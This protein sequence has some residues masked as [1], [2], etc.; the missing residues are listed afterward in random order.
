MVKLCFFIGAVVLSVF[1]GIL[2]VNIFGSEYSSTIFGFPKDIVIICFG[3]I[4]ALFGA[5]MLGKSS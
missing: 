3:I 1:I 5:F 4:G 2:V